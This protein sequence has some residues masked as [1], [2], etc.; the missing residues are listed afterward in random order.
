LLRYNAIMMKVILTLVVIAVLSCPGNGRLATAAQNQPMPEECEAAKVWESTRQER[1]EH[2][3]QRRGISN[4]VQK[5]FH[6]AEI[7][8]V[9]DDR[10][11]LLKELCA[12]KRL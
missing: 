8:R 4:P 3:F 9:V 10:I 11:R 2:E 7:E 6:R 1:I 5:D 12:Q